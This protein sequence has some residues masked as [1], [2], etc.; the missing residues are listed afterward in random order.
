MVDIIII[1]LKFNTIYFQMEGTNLPLITNGFKNKKFK[2]DSYRNCRQ[3][4]KLRTFS[5][6]I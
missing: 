2:G 4:L 3:K 6:K 1:L 5:I